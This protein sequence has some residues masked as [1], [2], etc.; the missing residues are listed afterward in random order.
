VAVVLAASAAHASAPGLIVF[1][2]NESG[3]FTTQLY[4][5][6]P[7]G[8]GLTQLTST[9][10]NALDPAFS[11]SGARIAFIRS[12]FGLYTMNP[13]GNGL[14]RLTTNGRDS[15]PAWSPD[16]KWI[17][18]VR[19]FKTK[20]RAWIIPATGGKQRLLARTPPA[21]R[22]SWTK[23]G[24]LIPTGGDLIRVDTTTGRVQKYY[25]ANIDAI[26]GL[27]SVTVSPGVSQLTYVGAR[28]PIP[29]DME[30]GEG[31]CQRFGLYL[32]SL[33]AKKKTPHMIVKDAGAAGFSPNGSQIV[34]AAGG[35][36]V[37]RSIATGELTPI[38]TPNLTPAAGAP[39]TWR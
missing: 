30:C 36:L 21:G 34:F 32:E 29:G 25:G 17:S 4:A 10:A 7:S 13:D 19:P 37:I 1:S 8:D 33:T 35:G 2:A 31:P 15:Y 23:A 38:A 20:W 16:G 12:G 27:N 18:F 3:T 9:G 6:Q 24:L 39:P 5:I 26:W 11:P 14:K 22:P 28:E